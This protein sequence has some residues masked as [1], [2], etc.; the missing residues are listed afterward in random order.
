MTS[1]VTKKYTKLKWLFRSI[2]F[3]IMSVPCAYFVVVGFIQGEPVEKVS[4]GITAV[5]ALILTLMNLILKANLRSRIWIILLGVSFC[6]DNFKTL[7]WI[8]C[9]STLLDE[10]VLTPLTKYFTEKAS[11]NKEID[12]RS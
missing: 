12:K 7:I 9:I 1:K 6:L 3:L 2:S 10:L 8:M 4:L 5:V 11:V